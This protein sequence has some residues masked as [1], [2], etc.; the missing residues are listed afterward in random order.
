MKI[1]Y[2][3][4]GPWSHQLFDKILG[5]RELEIAFVVP[6]F[7]SRDSGLESRCRKHGIPFVLLKD[8]NQADSLRTLAE[9]GCNLFLS[10][11]FNQIIR[12][13]LL[14]VPPLGFIN[15]HAGALPFY[16]GRNV[17]NWALINGERRIGVTVHYVDLGIDTGDII[18]QD[19][20]DIGDEDDY[21][22]LLEKL[23]VQCSDT[24]LKA[25][26]SILS[27]RPRRIPQATIHP[28]GFYCSR[29]VEGDEDVDWTWPARQIHNFVRALVPPG[30]GA[31]FSALG[32]SYAVHK[33]ELISEAPNYIGICGAVVG[34][35]LDG[36]VVKAGDST[37]KLKLVRILANESAKQE[38][39]VPNFPLGTRL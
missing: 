36:V 20:V 22:T 16:R 1:G 2:F 11:S 37:I 31:R 30:P 32:Q 17:V 33:S 6:R 13:P 28:V 12:G 23:Y 39:L 34:R 35:G 29:R 38:V 10:M 7:D 4:D 26:K 14:Q 9:F 15:C 25:L 18:E 19:F 8:V 5:S 27:G 24:G 3:A 21:A